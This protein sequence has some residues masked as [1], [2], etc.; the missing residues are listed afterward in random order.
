MRTIGRRATWALAAR[1]MRRVLSLWTQTLLPPVVTGL[2][3]LA[4]F[5]GVLSARL[6]RSM[7]SATRASSSLAFW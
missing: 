3:F 1:E 6:T 5:G 2:I 7:G 4:V